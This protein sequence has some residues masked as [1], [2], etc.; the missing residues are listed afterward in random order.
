MALSLGVIRLLV[1]VMEESRKFCGMLM[2]LPLATVVL[3]E[4]SLIIYA[5]VVVVIDA[6]LS[7]VSLRFEEVC[8]ALSLI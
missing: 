4:L 8:P 6:S 5:F 7:D 2:S 3:R 1:V